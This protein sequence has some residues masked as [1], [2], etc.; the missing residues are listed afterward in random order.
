MSAARAQSPPTLLHPAFPLRAGT[1]SMMAPVATRAVSPLRP[2]LRRKTALLHASPVPIAFPS[3]HAYDRLVDAK[4]PGQSA[5]RAW[6]RF[7]RERGAGSLVWMVASALLPT[8]SRTSCLN[9]LA[10]V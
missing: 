9:S 3:F 7:K 10:G 8:V 5:A 6:L 4:L 2:L 1:N